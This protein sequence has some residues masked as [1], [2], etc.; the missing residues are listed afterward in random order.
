MN[1]SGPQIS[2]WSVVRAFS[3]WSV[4]WW[5]V[6]GWS[7]GKWSVVAGR[8]VGDFKETPHKQRTKNDLLAPLKLFLHLVF[9]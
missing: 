2:Y 5:S 1:F 7:V 8:L 3:R 4:G 6:V 9:L